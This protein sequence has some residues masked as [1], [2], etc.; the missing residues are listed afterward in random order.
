MKPHWLTS[1]AMA[2]KQARSRGSAL[3]DMSGIQWKIPFSP[4]LP[5]ATRQ[6]DSVLLFHKKKCSKVTDPEHST[7]LDHLAPKAVSQ[8]RSQRFECQRLQTQQGSGIHKGENLAV[9]N[10]FKS[11]MKPRINHLGVTDKQTSLPESLLIIRVVLSGPVQ[12]AKTT[13][14]LDTETSWNGGVFHYQEGTPK[15][16]AVKIRLKP[17]ESTAIHCH[18][19]LPAF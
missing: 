6:S 3:R 4:N 17:G 2:G 18:P 19:V 12:S 8:R 7:R 1:P 16:T 11:A 5:T 14:L 10:V 15:V 9:R 13:P